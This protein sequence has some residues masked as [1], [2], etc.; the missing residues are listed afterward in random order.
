MTAIFAPTDG[1]PLPRNN[2]LVRRYGITLADYVAMLRAQGGGCA[3][4]GQKPT[5]RNLAVDHDHATGKVRGLLC[6]PCNTGLGTLES[7]FPAKAADYLARLKFC[8]SCGHQKSINAFA[9]D[10][11]KSSGRCT[12]CKACR[13]Q[14]A[15]ARG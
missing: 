13:K 6:A 10:R 5:R 8:S 11:T 2:E 9:R 7:D 12:H 1:P 3:I 4:C 14:R 15:A